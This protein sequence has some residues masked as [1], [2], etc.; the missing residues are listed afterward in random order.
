MTHIEKPTYPSFP[1]SA[2]KECDD[3]GDVDD[4]HTDRARTLVED[5]ADLH[6]DKH[7]HHW[8]PWCA[9]CEEDR[10]APVW[11]P[12]YDS[13]NPV[14]SEHGVTSDRA[15][16]VLGGLRDIWRR[17]GSGPANLAEFAELVDVPLTVA[18]HLNRLVGR[19]RRWESVTH[20]AN[21][22]ARSRC[23]R[24]L[25]TYGS[26]PADTYDPDAP[27]V[28]DVADDVVNLA[29]LRERVEPGALI[30]GVL[31]RHAYAVLRG[32]DGS[33]KTFAALD[34]ALCIATGTPWHGHAV[35]QANVLFIAGEGAHG[36]DRRVQAWEEA[37]GVKVPPDAL[38]ILPRPVD[39]HAGTEVNGLAREI[40]DRQIGLVIVDTLRRVSGSADGNS[41]AMGT[42]IDNLA[43]L[44]RETVEGSV[45]VIAHTGKDDSDTRGFSGIEDDADAV[46]HA[47][48][49]GG[50]R[51]RLILRNSKQKDMRPHADVVLHA[52][53]VGD[54]LALMQ[55][56]SEAGDSV[57]AAIITALEQAPTGLGG[58][59]LFEVIGGARRTFY[60]SVG[61]LVEAGRVRREGTRGAFSYSL[62]R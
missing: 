26:P 46:W 15:N 34:W 12:D 5:I 56:D 45:L 25:I 8:H 27:L 11:G 60:R 43:R 41:S 44:R 35:E 9:I 54:S 61:K 62:R 20:G 16:G 53:E 17:N 1:E 30:A 23:V 38:A 48:R 4:R 36:L 3:I 19:E 52:Q 22:T 33:F 24:W 49:D 47:R 37:N 28:T 21:G 51:E 2:W 59:E 29:A 39:L 18:D 42:V 55:G 10:L 14:L 13:I 57:E 40:R 6:D 7:L 32:R 50:N 58:A 31:P